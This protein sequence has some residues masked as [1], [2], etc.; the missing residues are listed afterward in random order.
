MIAKLNTTN[1]LVLFLIAHLIIWTVVPAL[2]N[3]NLPL[4]TIEALA[5]ASDINWGYDKHPPLSALFVWFTYSIFGANDWAYYLLSQIFIVFSFYLLWKFSENFLQN[6]I[7]ILISVLILESIVFFN[8]TSPEFNVYVCQIPLKVLVVYYFWKSVNGN[9]LINWILVSIFCALGMLSHYSFFFLILSLFLY[10][11]FFSKKKKNEIKFFYFAFLLFLIILSPHLYWLYENDFITLRYAFSRG[12]LESKDVFS[13]IV[14]PIIFLLK[15][16]GILSLFFLSL[17]SM[18][19]FKNKKIKFG[20]KNKKDKFLLFITILPIFLVLITSIFTGAKIRT[21]W[22]STFYVFFGLFMIYFFRNKI[23]LMNINKFLYLLG[24]IFILSPSTYGYVSL[25]NDFKRTDYPGKEIARLVQNKWDQN[26]TNEIKFV[27]G[28]EWSAGNLSY[29]LSSRPVWKSQFKNNVIDLKDNEGVIYT[30]NP[31][32]LKQIC[33]G[34]F[35]TIKPVGY[36]M[37]GTR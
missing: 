25:T 33:P 9:D 22:M 28:D 23:N 26:F 15:Q 31:K 2:T 14:N 20:F 30:G 27:V 13:H 36:C 21:M 18:I 19:S 35:G 4:D 6:K 1:L 17:L 10:F 11:V 5:W 3:E 7:L 34:F 8:Y 24:F 29:H 32:I 37:I 16:I 12:G